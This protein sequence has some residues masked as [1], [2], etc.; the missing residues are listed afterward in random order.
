M[1]AGLFFLNGHYPSLLRAAELKA[2]DLRM[3]A[4]GTHKR[5]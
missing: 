1:V 5:G 4:R 3:Y 2:F